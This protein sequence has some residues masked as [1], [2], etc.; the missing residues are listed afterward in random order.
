MSP[1]IF[2]H[3]AGLSGDFW[4]KQ[5][6]HFVDAEAIDLP[7]HGKS[8][9]EAL[10][11]ISAY[12]SWVADEVREKHPGPVTLAGHSMGSLVALEVAARNPDMVG[13]LILISTAAEMRVHPDLLEAARQRDAGAAAMVVKWSLPRT[14]GYGRP[15]DWVIGMTNDFIASAEAGVMADDFGACDEYDT[16]LEMAERVRCPSLLLLG[17]HDK[18]TKPSAAQPLAAALGDA[19]IVVI[20]KVGHMMPLEKPDEVNEAISLFLTIG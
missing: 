13:G 19:R 18:M 7:G 14:S 20:E 10:Q 4:R 8:D 15:K 3:G 11:T 5:T 2:V 6:E 12:A 9:D 17:E 1:I 16:A